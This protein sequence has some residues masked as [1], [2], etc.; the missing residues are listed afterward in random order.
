MKRKGKQAEVSEAP[1]PPKLAS[2]RSNRKS[3]L[4]LGRTIAAERE[5]LET[6]S[7]RMAARKKG[8]KKKVIRF[9]ITIAVFVVFFGFAVY[10]IVSMINKD[11]ELNEQEAEIEAIFNPTIEI[12]DMDAVL[13]GKAMTTRMRN[14]IGQAEVDFK[15][16]KYQPVKAVIPSGSIREV[17]FYLE[18]YNGYIKTTIDRGTGVTVEDAD[19]MLRYLSGI[20]VEDFEYIDVRVDG[21]GYWK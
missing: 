11:A 9:F 19:R 4:K 10:L 16:L 18:G 7:E 6:S 2:R 17:D 1:K 5:R 21:K 14:Y 3:S 15:D 20:G 12:L 13:T 8:K